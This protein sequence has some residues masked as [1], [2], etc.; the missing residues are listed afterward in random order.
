MATVHLEDMVPAAARSGFDAVSILGRARRSARARGWSDADLATLIADHGLV[1]DSM[2][3]AGDWLSP[4]PAGPAWMDCVY[5]AEEYLDVA[6]AIGA[7]TVVA[8]H[9]GAPHPAPACA[10]AFGRFCDRAADR[11]LRVAL[12]FPAW[13]TIGD[14][15]SAWEVVAA[16]DRPNGG[17][18]M[19]IWHHRRGGND[20]SM[21]DR[22]DPGKVFG[23]QLS[24][25]EA[26][27][28]G[29]PE[30]DVMHR[31]LPGQGRL[32]VAR[33]VARLDRMGVDAPVG[34]EVFD[35]DLVGTGPDVAARRLYDSLESVIGAADQP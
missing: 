8:V 1:V 35:A 24:D 18:L 22:V 10:E 14:L 31:L 17:L 25:A 2:E 6:A 9:F 21:L 4:P 20:D 23:I 27:P 5:G 12:E 34:I 30:A 32:G 28:V 11:K 7:E 13:A 3:A 16:A 26:E 15:G 33:L 29:P 19:D